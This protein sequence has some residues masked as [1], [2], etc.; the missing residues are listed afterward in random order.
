MNAAGTIPAAFSAFSLFIITSN[1][2]AMKYILSIIAIV[3][4]FT[5]TNCDSG[6]DDPEPA[7]TEEE[8]QLS[9]LAKTWIPGTVTY[10]GDVITE[11]FDGFTLNITKNKTYT[12]AGTMGG[13][14]Y[15]P[16]KNAGTWDFKDGDLNLMKRNDGVEMTV[17]VTDDTLEL[18][19]DMAEENGRIAGLGSYKFELVVK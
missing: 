18:T 13:F 9:R 17:L 16:F 8:K 4:V 11:D 19:F 1:H 6:P 3:T 2:I 5:L 15:E 10:A 12:V 14:D 7:I